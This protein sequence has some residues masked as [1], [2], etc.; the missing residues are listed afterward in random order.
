MKIRILRWLP[1][2]LLASILLAVAGAVFYGAKTAQDLLEGNKKLK[3]ALASLSHEDQ[4]GFAK[5]LRQET[6]DGKLYSTIRFVET[7]RGDLLTP[8]LEKTYE[9]EGDVVYFD[10]LI[11]TFPAQMVMDGKARSMY[12]WRRIYG[13]HQNP[14]DGFPIETPGTHPERYATLLK[15]L[16]I[17]DQKLFWEEIWKLANNPESL[18]KQG[19]KAIYGN[20]VYKRLKPGLIYVFKIGTDGQVYPETVPDL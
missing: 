1:L 16:R 7:V 5:V 9:I 2:A 20:A 4:I 3:A 8:V 13:E 11:I 10:A 12:L 18:R 17:P 6:R 15:T 14:A 19:I